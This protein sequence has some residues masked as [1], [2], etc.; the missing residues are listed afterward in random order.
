MAE[1]TTDNNNRKGTRCKK[2][3]PRVDMTPMVDLG[4]LLITFF[5]LSTTL[6]QPKTMDLIMPHNDGDPSP[7]KASN[8]MT[9]LLGD[10][11]RIA[12][13]EGLPDNPSVQYTSY[14]QRNG[15]GNIIRRKRAE[16]LQR[17]GKNQLMV[18]IKADQ[19]ASYKNIV[20]IMDEMLI[21][22]VES[23]TLADMTAQEHT[24]LT[25]RPVAVNH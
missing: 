17:T 8:A 12:W 3:N 6:M 2:N 10:H 1:I 11:N 22:K 16:I 4:F 24:Y 25:N 13:Y 19:H 21:N 5:M 20:D 14:G 15:I 18:L 9:L 7:L 23:Y